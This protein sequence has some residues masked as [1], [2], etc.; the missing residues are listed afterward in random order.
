MPQYVKPALLVALHQHLQPPAVMIVL[1]VAT[2]HLLALQ[3]AKPACQEHTQRPLEHRVSRHARPACQEATQHQ[4]EHQTSQPARPACQE[5]T[6]RQLEH[7]TSQPARAAWQVPTQH[8]TEHQ[9]SQPAKVATQE[10]TRHPLEHL[11]TQSAK[12]ALWEALHLH[13]VL[14]AVLIV[15]LVATHLLMAL[16]A[17]KHAQQAPMHHSLELPTL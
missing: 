13:M 16:Q 15:W 10:A 2:H 5:A 8:P 1:Q 14:L 9:T 17:A 11:I 6:Q 12:A 3:S 4:L 7:Q